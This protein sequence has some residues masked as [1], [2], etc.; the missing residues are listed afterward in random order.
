MLRLAWGLAITVATAPTTLVAAC[1]WWAAGWGRFLQTIAREPSSSSGG[2]NNVGPQLTVGY[3]IG[4]GTYRLSNGLLSV[5]GSEWIGDA[6]YNRPSNGSFMQTGGAHNING[7]LNLGYGG[8]GSYSLTA[9]TL[10]ASQI[11]GGMGTSTFNFNGGLL[12]AISGATSPFMSGLTNAYVQGGG[13]NIDSNGQSIT[14]SQPLLD[15]GGGGGLTKYGLGTLTLEGANTY[16]GTTTVTNGVLLV[17][18]SLAN[19]GSDKV[20]LVAGANGVYGN[21]IGNGV[22]VRSVAA[23]GT[24]IGLGSAVANPSAGEQASTAD[25]L[26]GSNSSGSA[27][28]VSM[29][30]RT[31]A[32]GEGLFSD[33]VE[34]SGMALSGSS[35]GQT[36][37]FVLQMTYNPGLILSANELPYLGWLN[38][39]TNTWENA[40]LGNYGSSNDTFV[41][42]R[43]WNGDTTLGDWG[44]NTTNDTVW[45]VVDHNSD[46][47]AVPE[48]STLALLG[49]AAGLMSYGL[50]RRKKSLAVESTDQDETDAPAILSFPSYRAESKRRAA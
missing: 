14:I 7:T 8:T 19:N 24:Y 12:Q 26:A 29:Q 25:I 9:G 37:P 11:T 28:A 35:T 31:Q 17:S 4:I 48:P 50:R 41:G 32:L 16:T 22:I 49:V 20:F 44:V 46:F 5:Q 2:T 45:A 43:A 23:G 3:D 33:V 1:Y 42:I 27:Q 10:S 36:A 21:G 40:V 30:W 38:P 18:G 34:V 47:A 15:G 6:A 13:A 39:T